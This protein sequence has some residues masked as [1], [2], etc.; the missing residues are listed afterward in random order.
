LDGG[1]GGIFK[2]RNLLNKAEERAQDLYERMTL[3]KTFGAVRDK[4]NRGDGVLNY[5]NYIL[6]V[7]TW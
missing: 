4:D 1:G 7:I 2:G 3:R 5:I 6:S